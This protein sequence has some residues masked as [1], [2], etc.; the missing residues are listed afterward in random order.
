ME[1][2]GISYDDARD[3]LLEKMDQWYKECKTIIENR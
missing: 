2:S 1:Y 3:P